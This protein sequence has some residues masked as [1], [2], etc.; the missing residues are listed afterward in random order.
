[1][2][3]TDMT[4]FAQIEDGKVVQVIV[5]EQDVIDARPEHKWT[6]VTADR[7]VA[8]IGYDYDEQSDKFIAPEGPPLS[9]EMKAE[10]AALQY[11]KPSA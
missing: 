5:A 7:G 3:G 6:E 9:D 8:G 10:I 4:I 1:M 11:P 2:V